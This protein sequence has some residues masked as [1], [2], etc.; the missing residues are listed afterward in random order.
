MMKKQYYL[1]K[2]G[3]SFLKENKKKTYVLITTIVLS[4]VSIFTS[5][6]IAYSKVEADG[7]KNSKELGTKANVLVKNSYQNQYDKLIVMDDFKSIGK[8]YIFAHIFNG[9]RAEF[10]CTVIDKVEWEKHRKPCYDNVVGYYPTTSEEIMISKE[11]LEKMGVLSPQIGMKVSLKMVFD[12]WSING[13]SESIDNFI[14]AGYYDDFIEGSDKGKIYFSD[15]FLDKKVELKEKFDIYLCH[16]DEY[17]N[18]LIVEK[19]LYDQLKLLDDQQIVVYDSGIHKALSEFIGGV[20]V[21]IVCIFIVLISIYTIIFNIMTISISKDIQQYRLLTSIGMKSTEI[22]FLVYYQNIGILIQAVVFALVLCIICGNLVLPK[23]VEKLYLQGYGSLS[24]NMFSLPIYLIAVIGSAMTIM[25]INRNSFAQYINELYEKSKDKND[26]NV[27]E[28]LSRGN[29][30]IIY[31]LAIHNVLKD[32]KKFWLTIVS[33]F[34]GCEVALCSVFISNGT[35]TLNKINNR[36]DF[37]IGTRKEAVHEYL[38]ELDNAGDK[39]LLNENMLMKLENIKGID[40]KKI[41]TT[42]GAY[43][44]ID[45]SL[46]IALKPRAEAIVDKESKNTAATIQVVDDTFIS[47]LK[48]YVEDKNLRINMDSFIEGEG[49]I[50]LHKNELSQKLLSEADLLVNETFHFFDSDYELQNGG[51]EYLNSGYLDIE[52]QGFPELEMTWIGDGINYFIISE[53]GYDNLNLKNQIFKINVNINKNISEKNILE[54]IKSVTNS[55]KSVI[56]NPYY[57]VSKSD[58]VRE[59]QAYIYATNTIMISLS[60]VLFL[61]GITNYVN[62]MLTS[63]LNR[64][65]D[66]KL[67]YNIGMQPKQLRKMLAFEGGIYGATI[68]II[69]LTAGIGILGLVYLIMKSSISYFKFIF[70]IETIFIILGSIALLCIIIPAT[71]AKS[72]R[73]EWL[74][75]VQA[76][77]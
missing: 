4:I 45:Y 46:D 20:V 70:P 5:I 62:T 10:E 18:S 69:F 32:K 77:K 57:I 49:V 36:P 61:I 14:L 9:S 66:F 48:T 37:L 1:I 65:K 35:N 17:K 68:A 43:A 28:L 50:L 6:I 72:K 40:Y 23:I 67:M 47:K 26:G 27:K 41:K 22:K 25:V 34:L 12:N 44:S 21:A 29:V 11:N 15:S 16:K 73:G 51:Y 74:L 13:G 58:L 52:K 24:K 63:I 59:A 19:N 76:R 7:V 33:L 30:N 53:K 71:Y 64:E 56:N 2:L 3:N 31:G 55:E 8:E 54:A 39:S 75:T 42:K 60:I 38:F